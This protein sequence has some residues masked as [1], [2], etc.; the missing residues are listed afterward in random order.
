MRLA[1]ILILG[2]ALLVLL[3]SGGEQRI[4]GME[5][6]QFAQLAMTTGLLTL[7]AAGFWHQFRDR[8]GANLT[9]LLIWGVLAAALVAGYA[10]RDEAR[11]LG[12]R[13]LG[14]VRP[15]SAVMGSDGSVTITRRSDGDFHVRAEV[16]GQSQGFQ[17]DTGASSVVLTAENAAG[18][19]I[20]PAESEFSIR[21][22]TA[23]GT[24]LAAPAFLDTL[25]V[26]SIVERRV[27]ALVSRPGALRENLL[28]MSFLDRLASFEVRG[29]RL[30]LR[31]R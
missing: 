16:N 22:S 27:P 20:R 28:G 19:G 26:G 7:L 1:G 8:M 10:Y 13:M 5:P 2:G 9:A 24:T 18:L 15:G 3:L 4:V 21:V 11:S 31:D 29:D 12:D 14:A 23:N 30:I 17:F 6:D 25:R